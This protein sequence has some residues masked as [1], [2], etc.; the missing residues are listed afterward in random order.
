MGSGGRNWLLDM[1]NIRTDDHMRDVACRFAA[2]CASIV[3]EVVEASLRGGGSTTVYIAADVHDTNVVPDVP[4]HLPPKARN[5]SRRTAAVAAATA[6]ASGRGDER[7]GKLVKTLYKAASRAFTHNSKVRASVH[8]TLCTLM[9]KCPVGAGVWALLPAIACAV[10]DALHERFQHE[11]RHVPFVAVGVNAETDGFATLIDILGARAGGVDGAAADAPRTIAIHPATRFIFV[12][13]DFDM[14]IPARVYAVV[15]VARRHGDAPVSIA[16]RDALVAAIGQRWSHLRDEPG[17]A[18]VLHALGRTDYGHA[19]FRGANVG[20]WVRVLAVPF[21]REPLLGGDAVA[22][23]GVARITKFVELLLN[24]DAAFLRVIGEV[25]GAACAAAIRRAQRAVRKYDDAERARVI[26]NISIVWHFYRGDPG[27]T[28]ARALTV[29]ALE[30]AGGY[31]AGDLPFSV[32]AVFHERAALAEFDE[33]AK[34]Q[35]S[36]PSFRRREQGLRATL[37]TYVCAARRECAC[38]VRGAR[39]QLTNGSVRVYACRCVCV[40]VS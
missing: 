13:D 22:G 19:Y 35:R 31:T 16:F 11:Y 38:A 23:D 40:C 36:A 14:L 15:R 9:V 28:A 25:F 32:A 1:A 27:F 21:L 20:T 2:H 26:R 29:A 6:T 30:A 3:S 5:A 10:A 34:R 4:R 8:S 18:A 24:I 17:A 37:Q 33:Y 39:M 7:I 12:S